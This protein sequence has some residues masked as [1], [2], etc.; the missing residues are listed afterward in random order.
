MRLSHGRTDSDG[1]YWLS[2]AQ[3][4]VESIC[5]IMISNALKSKIKM[6][7]L[8]SPRIF[9][10]AH[11]IAYMICLYLCNNSFMETDLVSKH[12]YSLIIFIV[13]F[14]I[15]CS[16]VNCIITRNVSCGLKLSLKLVYMQT[17][18]LL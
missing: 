16:I 6:V 4:R 18:S 3:S 8:A 10:T 1:K 17:L 14:S 13:A 2:Y 9:Q 5:S 15:I 11:I 7:T 12:K